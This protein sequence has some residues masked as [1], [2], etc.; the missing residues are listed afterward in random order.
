MKWGERGNAEVDDETKGVNG[1]TR[2]VMEKQSDWRKNRIGCRS[3][4]CQFGF[5]YL[6]VCAQ[7][8]FITVAASFVFAS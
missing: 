5:L 4:G 3:V 6:V 7:F 1:T 2:T 8:Q